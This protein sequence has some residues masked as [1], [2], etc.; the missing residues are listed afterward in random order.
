MLHGYES[1]T[2]IYEEANASLGKQM[3]QETL[4]SA[5]VGGLFTQP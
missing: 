4:I 1:W 3:P 2:L 5:V